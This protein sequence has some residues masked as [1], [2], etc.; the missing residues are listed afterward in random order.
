MKVESAPNSSFPIVA[1][2]CSAGGLEA[3]IELLNNLTPD[4]GMAFVLIQHLDP[5][6]ESMLPDILSRKTSMPVTQAEQNMLMEQDNFYIIPP[7]KDMELLDGHI[8]LEP[9]VNKPFHMPIDRF[10]TSL[11]DIKGENAIGVVLSGG[12]TDGTIG[13]KAIK[14]ADG[15]TIA[16]DGSAKFQSMPRSAIAEGIVDFVLSPE[17]IAL[18]LSKLGRYLKMLNDARYIKKEDVDEKEELQG[19]FKQLKDTVRVDFNHY[20]IAS[21]SRRVKRRMMLIDIATIIEYNRYLKGHPVELQLLYNDI[22]INVTKF[23]RD[24]DSFKYLQQKLIPQIAKNKLPGESIRL[25]VP[26]CSTGQEAYSIAMILCEVLGTSEARATVQIFATDLSERAINKARQG[27]YTKSEAVDISPERLARFFDKTDGNYRINKLIRDICVFAPHDVLKDPPFA[28][29][30]FISC[31]NLFIYL[32]ADSQKKVVDTFHYALNGNG[33]LMLG[34]AETIGS[35]S[36]FFKQID[37]DAKTNIY[38]RDVSVRH[39]LQTYQPK[40]ANINND[41]YKDIPATAK[42]PNLAQAVDTLLLTQYITPSVVINQDF[43]ILQIRGM[44]GTFLEPAAGSASLNLLK[45]ARP[46]LRIDL[47][48]A[49][50]K[51][52]KTGQP[53]RRDGLEVKIRNVIYSA[54]I[55]VAQLSLIPDERYFLVL[56]Y[57]YPQDIASPSNGSVRKSAPHLLEQKLASLRDDMTAIIEEREAANEELQTANEEIVSSNEELHTINEELQTSKEEMESSNEE[58]TTVNEQLQVRNEQLSEIQEYTDGII[59]TIAEAM[60]VVDRSLIIKSANESFFKIF[61]TTAEETEG[62]YFFDLGNGQ[63]NIPQ[64]RELLMDVIPKKGFF[65]GFE[66]T[67]TFPGIGKKI[68]S[69]NARLLTQKVQKTELIF[70]AIQDITE[71]MKTATILKEKE[72]FHNMANNAPVMIWAAGVDKMGTFFNNTWLE[73]TGRSMEAESGNGWAANIHPKDVEHYMNVYNDSFEKRISF[74]VEYRLRRH[75]GIYRWLMTACKPTYSENKFTGYLCTCTDITDQKMFSQKL[76][77][78][79][80]E[81]TDD[82]QVANNNLLKSNKDLEQYAYIASHDL[83]E[84]L[85]KIQTFSDLLQKKYE[86]EMPAEYN[87]YIEK[88]ADSA[89]RMRFLIEDLLN[90]SSIS[91]ATEPVIITD[92]NEIVKYVIDDFDLPG[93]PATIHYKGLP[94]VKAVPLQM[95]QLFNNLISN[96]IKFKKLDAPLDIIITAG[97]LASKE[98]HKHPELDKYLSYHEIIFRDN[99]IGFNQEF[100]E[101]IFVIFKRLH[102][103]QTYK[104]TGIGLALCRK[105]MIN[106]GGEIFAVS[107]EGEGTAFHLIFPV[108]HP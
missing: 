15:M 88:I 64:L 66:V 4:T 74:S 35:S 58:L 65:N 87:E 108:S 93:V 40:S 11:A 13:L 41:A 91:D 71:H 104:G 75:D 9:R 86:K 79:V 53:V 63:W 100:A 30:D 5:T 32:D 45:M 60:I 42:A 27:I 89:V 94:I 50:H 107:K 2:G 12:A 54:G 85:R 47:R 78:N 57:E 72:L 1:I 37:K 29:I 70:I 68:M 67:H 46:G 105:I 96:S 84:P 82:L 69:L 44:T 97:E 51:C 101:Q 26:A 62:Y 56:F 73:F 102:G 23:F 83:Q 20:K 33:Y 55:E 8:K 98:L 6:H 95:K 90:F 76:E 31:C 92:L 103:K 39:A 14:E 28:R 16:Q 77:I 36:K 99:G 38:R 21:I 3:V 18:E 17:N 49:I 59:A 22:L 52:I 10:F 19:I 34:K 81:R 106:H 25:W 80:K 7:D 43:E 24:I 61:K 48:T